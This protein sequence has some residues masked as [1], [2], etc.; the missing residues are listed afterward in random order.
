MNPVLRVESY[1]EDLKKVQFIIEDINSDSDL[2]LFLENPTLDTI[3]VILSSNLNII[4]NSLFVPAGTKNITG[5]LD[6]SEKIA[7]YDSV[8]LLA[9]FK[10]GNKL[11]KI[12]YTA[13]DIPQL[14]ATTFGNIIVEISPKFVSINDHIDINI[15]ARSGPIWVTINNKTFLVKVI[16]GMGS[17]SIDVDKFATSSSALQNIRVYISGI[18]EKLYFSGNVVKILPESQGKL[19]VSA[20]SILDTNLSILDPEEISAVLYPSSGVGETV[21]ENTK[22]LTTSGD[23]DFTLSS[24]GDFARVNSYSACK[25]SSNLGLVALSSQNKDLLTL[26]NI[27]DIEEIKRIKSS[28]VYVLLSQLESQHSAPFRFGRVTDINPTVGDCSSGVISISVEQDI[29]NDTSLIYIW[30]LDG[31]LKGRKFKIFSQHREIDDSRDPVQYIWHLVPEDSDDVTI[32]VGDCFNFVAYGNTTSVASLQNNLAKI[33][34]LPYIEVDGSAVSAVNPQIASNYNNAADESHQ[35][36]YVI[37]EGN[38]NELAQLFFYSFDIKTGAIYGWK[39]LTYDGENKNPRISVDKRNNLHIVWESSRCQPGQ[40]YYSILGPDSRPVLN[41]VAASVL[42]KQSAMIIN[43]TDSYNNLDD[44]IVTYTA[45]NG[46]NLRELD[47]AGEPTG[48]MWTEFTTTGGTVNILNDG[49]LSISGNGTEEKFAAFAC[50]KRDENDVEF[51]DE[52]SQ[53]SYQISFTLETALDYNDAF[54]NDELTENDIKDLYND[55]KSD[56]IPSTASLLVPS[57]GV[58]LYEQD[59]SIFTI[60]EPEYIYNRIIPIA[61]SYNAPGLCGNASYGS[62]T[63][64]LHLQHFMLAIVPEQV[65]F[66]AVNAET[67]DEQSNRLEISEE[68]LEYVANIEQTYYTRRFKL[69]LITETSANISD[70][71]LNSQ[72]YHILRLFGDDISFAESHDYKIAVHY[73]KL[74]SEQLEYRSTVDAMDIDE[75]RIRYSGNIIISVDEQVQAADTFICDFADNYIQFD[76]GLG[77]TMLGEYRPFNIKPHNGTIN[78]DID[79]EFDYTNITIGPHSVYFSEYLTHFAKAD[80]NVTKMLV[81]NVFG[82][83]YSAPV[84]EEIYGY[85]DSSDENQKRYNLTFGLDKDKVQLSQIPITFCGRNS[86]P[87]ICIDKNEKIHIS[88]QSNRD[89]NW[90]IYY[91]SGLDAALPFRFDTRITNSDKDSL[92]SSIAIDNLGRRLITWHDNRSGKFNIYAARSNIILSDNNYCIRDRLKDTLGLI[93]YGA[94]PDEYEYIEDFASICQLS[95]LFTNDTEETARYHF[96]A[97]FFFDSARTSLAAMADSRLDISNWSII[98]DDTLLPMPYN[99]I[100]IEA[101]QTIEVIY[102]IHRQLGLS[103]EL[104]YVTITTDDGNEL[105]V[106]RTIAFF[107][108][109]GQQSLCN[110][111]VVYTNQTEYT[112]NVF[113]IVDVFADPE[114]TQL[115]LTSNSQNDNTKWRHG[116]FDPFPQPGISVITGET[117]SVTYNPEILNLASSKWQNAATI[118]ALLCNTK[119]YV[120]VYV[121]IIEVGGPADTGNILI[122]SYA[123]ECQCSDV[124][125]NIWREDNVSKDWLCSGQGGMDIQLTNNDIAIYPS[126]AATQDGMVYITWELTTPER[127]H[128]P[129]I[130]FSIWDA[131]NDVFYTRSQGYYDKIVIDDGFF[132]P[133]ILI[134]DLQHPSFIFT[135]GKGIFKKTLSLYRS[136]DVAEDSAE[137]DNEFIFNNN[138]LELSAG[139]LTSCLGIDVHSDSVVRLYH[140]TSDMPI[141][142]VDKCR[143]KLDIRCPHGTYAIRFKNE[144]DSDWSEWIPVLPKLY[145]QT[146]SEDGPLYNYIQTYSVSDN[147]I[148]S[149]WVLSLGDGNKTVSCQ[150]MTFFGRTPTI[151]RNIIARYKQ[152]KYTI[153]FYS[154]DDTVLASNYNGY[155]VA[156]T[157]S[158]HIIPTNVSTINSERTEVSTITIYVEFDDKDYLEELLALNS[159]D[160]IGEGEQSLTFDVIMQGK[161]LRNQTLTKVE[162]ATLSFDYDAPPANSDTI[163]KSTYKGTFA[164]SIADGFD[165]KDGLA[166]VLLNI[167]CPCIESTEEDIECEAERKTVAELQNEIAEQV[168]A[169]VIDKE[170]FKV[171]YTPDLLCSFN[172]TSCVNGEAPVVSDAGD[173]DNEFPPDYPGPVSCDSFEFNAQQRAEPCFYFRDELNSTRWF[174]ESQEF[175]FNFDDAR[176]DYLKFGGESSLDDV[177]IMIKPNETISFTPALTDTCPDPASSSSGV[178]GTYGRSYTFTMPLQSI[179]FRHTGEVGNYYC[180]GPSECN[181]GSAEKI[182][183]ASSITLCTIPEGST[184][185]DGSDGGASWSN[186]DV[187]LGKTYDPLSPPTQNS[188]S[189]CLIATFANG[190]SKAELIARGFI[191]T[192]GILRFK[193]IHIPS[194]IGY[195]HIIDITCGAT[196]ED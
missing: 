85:S 176:I 82:Y 160:G 130:Y 195:A 108:P 190:V 152:P 91:T 52:F 46:L 166:A 110:I 75:Q 59:N 43:G 5:T 26:E 113:F 11:I 53:L 170:R 189:Q 168:S 147:H 67:A 174:I 62:Q 100:E 127:P 60:A 39:Q 58:S 10:Q 144:S 64:Q 103:D 181:F 150:L 188:T 19:N 32:S 14:V 74:R 56:F 3:P 77:V 23:I 155:P 178:N 165:N 36:I 94:I 183:K 63:E 92:A 192:N 109:I 139:D 93:D 86:M 141:A 88:Y 70:K 177:L 158:L 133:R 186:L 98:V 173:E 57:K 24:T 111:P 101:G 18:D 65:R 81:G 37:A 156:S 61:G 187:A 172:S 123:I 49:S 89:N 121:N 194:G 44:Q 9:V 134:T 171:Q 185:N 131:E 125:A 20:S 29:W 138:M 55:W 31:S 143:I 116:S 7:G 142:L 193:L 87:A 126:A 137:I 102:D 4:S 104:Y 34:P 90:E 47:E 154:Q 182:F 122:D 106:H 22:K 21:N 45:A 124:D 66:L 50:L 72:R 136:D 120:D 117:I 12:A 180:H 8:I 149:D 97:D 118:T 38:V 99:G 73:A 159:I 16:N 119:Y 35:Y 140:E 157:Q 129:D 114:K 161:T 79:V 167:P 2:V 13:I 1:S 128:L 30:I 95:F 84:Y 153:T 51:S 145:G 162:D 48:D 191:T 83:N 179:I 71:K 6:I 184:V 169:L 80:R 105:N 196:C 151:T 78:A 69:A 25:I 146:S 148:I 115:V 15:K 175:E 17:I 28:R 112:H 27:T 107:C 135:N 68:D 41:E 164:I 96:I 42:D 163:K 33:S 132:Q 40:I 76:I 54:S